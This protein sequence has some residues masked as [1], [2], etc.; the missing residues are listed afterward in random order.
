MAAQKLGKWEEA[1]AAWE[2]SLRAA[3]ND[4]KAKAALKET[5]RR[6]VAAERPRRKRRRKK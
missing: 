3:P 5:T 6:A 2:E 4:A 1:R